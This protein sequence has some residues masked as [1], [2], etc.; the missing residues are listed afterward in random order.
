VGNNNIPTNDQVRRF[1]HLKDIDF[2]ELPDKKVHILI[3]IDVPEAH[4]PLKVL[5]GARKEPYVLKSDPGWT[6]HG[7]LARVF[8]NMASFYY[9]Q[10]ST[11]H[12]DDA[13]DEDI[14]RMFRMDSTDH[15]IRSP[16]LSI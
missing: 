14:Q 7:P 8:S 5:M 6:I 15:D 12:P 9:I 2:P 3:G 13:L 10:T 1:K 11:Q 16:D 4:C